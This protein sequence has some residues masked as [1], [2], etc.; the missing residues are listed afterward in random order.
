MLPRVSE[1]FFLAFNAEVDFCPAM[2]PEDLAKAGPDLE[3][4]AKQ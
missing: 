2:N 1:A 4:T 3:R